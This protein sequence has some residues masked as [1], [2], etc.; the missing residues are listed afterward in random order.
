[1]IELES[2]VILRSLEITGSLSELLRVKKRGKCLLAKGSY[3]I[4]QHKFDIE[5]M[6]IKY[7]F[8]YGTGYVQT[9]SM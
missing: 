1:M 8:K 3:L 7:W 5:I 9:E 4:L 2:E 6:F